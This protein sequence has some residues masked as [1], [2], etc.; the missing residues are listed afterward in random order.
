MIIS[1]AQLSETE[2]YFKTQAKIK[3]LFEVMDQDENRRSR[4]ISQG[5]F[6]ATTRYKGLA[7]NF[8]QLH[9]KPLP[10]SKF[11]W[12]LTCPPN[13]QLFLW[14]AL[15]EGL[16]TFDTNIPS[17]CNSNLKAAILL[18]YHVDIDSRLTNLIVIDESWGIMYPRV[19]VS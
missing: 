15:T 3:T 16:S 5:K 11:L 8:T 13:I 2:F 1:V 4:Q 12:I 10:P 18:Q 19:T 9:R 6:I 14:K 7:S 17:R